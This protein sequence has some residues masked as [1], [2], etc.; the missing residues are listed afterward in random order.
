MKEDDIYDK[1]GPLYNEELDTSLK[2]L[3][4]EIGK[5]IIAPLFAW[6]YKR[7]YIIVIYGLILLGLIANDM[8]QRFLGL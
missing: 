4:L 8:M 6:I 2:E 5:E 3:K 1:R 7:P